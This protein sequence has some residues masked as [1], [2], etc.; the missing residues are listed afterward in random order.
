VI[1]VD[2]GINSLCVVVADFIHSAIGDDDVS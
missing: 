1:G 2:D